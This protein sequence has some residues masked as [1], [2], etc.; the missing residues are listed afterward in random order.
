MSCM[1]RIG[2]DAGD[3]KL[4]KCFFFKNCLLCAKQC[5]CQVL[6]IHIHHFVYSTSPQMFWFLSGTASIH[7]Q[8]TFSNH[9]FN[10]QS[11]IEIILLAN[12]MT[13]TFFLA[14]ESK[15]HITKE[16][17]T[18]SLEIWG[19]WYMTENKRRFIQGTFNAGRQSN[20]K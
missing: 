17:Q 10:D 9:I 16:K 18:K 11:T 7:S 13:R 14:D 4:C 19:V 5:S 1:L 12:I 2:L 3:I 20:Q 6:Y 15:M 8:H